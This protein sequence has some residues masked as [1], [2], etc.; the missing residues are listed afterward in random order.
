M[1][2]LRGHGSVEKGNWVYADHCGSG[3]ARES[4]MSGDF[5]AGCEIA[6]A[7]KPAPTESRSSYAKRQ[8]CLSESGH[9]AFLDFSAGN[10]L[11]AEASA[12]QK[13]RFSRRRK[14]NVL[15]S[16]EKELLLT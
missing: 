14:D 1:T 13:K 2:I 12:Q 16:I 9:R 8:R 6:F 10:K 7:S 11:D 5:Y 15:L 3:L 4:G